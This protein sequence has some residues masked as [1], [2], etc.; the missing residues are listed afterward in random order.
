MQKS[1]KAVFTSE[2][3]S[4]MDDLK[5]K[6]GFIKQLED[7][8]ETKYLRFC[9]P[10][11]P[12]QL[13]TLLGARVATNLISFI[14]HHPRRWAKL[15][16]V[17]ASEQQL[18]W[19][20]A[21]QLLEQYS[22]MQSSPQLRGFAWNVPYFI[23]WHAVI[24]VLD[25]LR[26]DPL[27]PDAVKAW[28]LIDAVYENNS[29]MLLNIKKPISVAVG[30]LCL[31]AFSACGAALTKENRS[32]SDPPEYITK[33][34]EQ[35]EAAKARKQ[36]VI[37]RN[38]GLE[39]L[40][41]E[42]RAKPTTDPNETWPGVGLRLAEGPIEAQPQQFPVAKQLANTVQGSALTGDDA[43]WLSDSLDD[44][45]FASGA[46]DMMDLDADVILA[47]EHWPDTSNGENI[48]WAQWDAWL[49]NDDPA[50]PNIGA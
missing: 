40:D 30:N 33:L 49:G 43:F 34:R 6:D 20:I 11:Q 25:T 22:M 14:A 5:I 18:V 23:Q 50:P 48:D 17:P 4:A 42:K 1:N 3:F 38:K 19:G 21:V 24:H 47:Q 39:R 32:L 29:D 45:F 37:T 7:M 31:K 12:L 15:D 36:A 10:S 44:G 35:R 41:G 16:R 2:E 27:H 46:A 28:R 26:A 13:L 9:D 8:I